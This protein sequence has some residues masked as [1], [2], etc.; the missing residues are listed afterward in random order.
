MGRRVNTRRIQSAINVLAAPGVILRGSIYREA[1]GLIYIVQTIPNYP[2][3]H[4]EYIVIGSLQSFMIYNYSHAKPI[5]SRHVSH[6][7]LLLLPAYGTVRPLVLLPSQYGLCPSIPFTPPSVTIVGLGFHL[8][9][10]LRPLA[11]R[12][13]ENDVVIRLFCRSP[14]RVVNLH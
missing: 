5:P 1:W 9:S 8:R 11:E 12:I 6:V 14:R 2:T 7:V 10:R 13:V 3:F 4:V